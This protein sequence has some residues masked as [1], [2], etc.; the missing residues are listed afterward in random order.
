MLDVRHWEFVFPNAACHRRSIRYIRPGMKLTALFAAAAA[1][2][3]LSSVS[4][5][6]HSWEETKALNEEH[7]HGG[8][9][10][11]EKHEAEG[12]EGH[13]AH[14]AEEHGEKEAH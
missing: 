7:A 11:G 8:H 2:L 5:E 6:R 13:E 12:E 1:G 3:F 10:G 4:C 14:G 9:H